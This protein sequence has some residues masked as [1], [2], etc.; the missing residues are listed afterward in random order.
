MP[1]AVASDVQPMS[2]PSFAVHR[3][4]Q[5]LVDERNHG[6]LTIFVGRS[7]ECLDLLGRG[8]HADQIDVHPPRENMGRRGLIRR[9]SS[10]LAAGDDEVIDR[11]DSLRGVN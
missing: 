7:D 10:L 5:Q 3:R 9:K 6:M 1:V 8:K 4:L 11:V 2:G